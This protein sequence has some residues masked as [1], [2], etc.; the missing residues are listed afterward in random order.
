MRLQFDDRQYVEA[1]RSIAEDPRVK[2]LGLVNFDT[3][4][5]DE[6]LESGIEVVSNQVQAC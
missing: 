5:M 6:V 2:S 4:H 3:T 1:C